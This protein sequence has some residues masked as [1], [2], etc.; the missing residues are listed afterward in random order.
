[1]KKWLTSYHPFAMVTIVFWSMA[2][3]LSRV[4]VGYLSSSSLGL[5]R[6]MT[7][8]I[9]LLPAVR[10]RKMVLPA[11]KDLKW[12]AASGV[13]GFFFYMLFFNTGCKFVTASA[14]SMV[15]AVVPVL[16]ALFAQVLQGESLNGVQWLA[17]GF[18]FAGVVILSF[19]KGP[20]TMNPGILWTLLAAVS[21]AGYNLLQKKLTKS[22]TAL[23]SAAYSIFA[24]TF[25]LMLFLPGTIQEI[26]TAPFLIILAVLL[27]GVFSSAAAYGSWAAAI[28]RAVKTSSVSNY[29]FVTPFLTTL[30]GYL[31]LGEKPDAASLIG[32][33]VIL[34][35]MAVFYYAGNITESDVDGTSK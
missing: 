34:S 5:L 14:S 12:F 8:T 17:T 4:A 25:L 22:Y 24:G 20:V 35:G 3:V 28:A 10:I 6:C 29:M 7:A 33:L 18:E 30:L 13:T 19:T 27:M 11:G 26:C 9:V 16:T 31:F 23:Q 15:I 1:M 21:L 32:G 2:Y